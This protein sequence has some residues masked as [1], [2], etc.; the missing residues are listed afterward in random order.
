MTPDLLVIIMV[1]IIAVLVSAL[2]YAVGVKRGREI[3]WCEHHFADLAKERARRDQHGRFVAIRGT[4][5]RH[6]QEAVP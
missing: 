5:Q 4:P 1:C 6:N 2:S 3:G